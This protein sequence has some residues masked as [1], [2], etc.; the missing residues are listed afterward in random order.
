M[1]IFIINN[2]IRDENLIF[3]TNNFKKKIFAKKF[4]HQKNYLQW[5]KFS[6]LITLLVMEK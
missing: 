1:Q 5:K 3:V 4:Y 6:S 2:I